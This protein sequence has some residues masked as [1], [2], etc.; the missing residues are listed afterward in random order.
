MTIFDRYPILSLL[1]A[2]PLA[3]ILLLVLM[4]MFENYLAFY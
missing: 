2:T 4:I 3:A 1:A